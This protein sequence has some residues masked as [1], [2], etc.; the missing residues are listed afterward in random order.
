MSVQI[1][2]L[3]GWHT[4]RTTHCGLGYDVTLVRCQTSMF[5]KWK[6]PYLLLQSL[7]DFHLLLLWK[8]HNRSQPRNEKPEQITL[9]EEW[10]LWF[11]PLNGEGLEPIVLP[12]KC[13]SGP[14]A[15]IYNRVVSLGCL[16]VDMELCDE[17]NNCTFSFIQIQLVVSVLYRKKSWE[18]FNF[19]WFF[20]TLCPRC[21]VTSDLI[22]INQHLELLGNQECYHNKIIIILKALS[23]KIIKRFVS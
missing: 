16:W 23:N 3:Q 11:Y 18:I 17:C 20:T 5:L 12:W 19:L 8:V 7:T 1:L 15:L 21:H 13:H 9:L 6:M 22:C 2:S 4:A 14:Q 10:K